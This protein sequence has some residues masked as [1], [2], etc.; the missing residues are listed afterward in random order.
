[1]ESLLQNPIVLKIRKFFPAAA[2]FGGFTWDSVTLG[3][4]VQTSDLAILL[5][6]YV[7]PKDIDKQEPANS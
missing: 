3:K 5:L 1:M 2:F 4:L 6:Y 7:S